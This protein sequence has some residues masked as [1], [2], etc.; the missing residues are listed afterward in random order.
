MSK[1]IAANTED[2][3]S[4]ALVDP[5]MIRCRPGIVRRSYVA[6][7]LR[8]IADSIEEGNIVSIDNL[9]WNGYS[10]FSGSMEYDEIGVEPFEYDLS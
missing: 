8:A 2:L 4:I 9:Q 3:Y 1:R 10:A 7:I 5:D 6:M